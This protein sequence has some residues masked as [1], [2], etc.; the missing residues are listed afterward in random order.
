[1]LLFSFLFLGLFNES[2]ARGGDGSLI[3]NGGNTVMCRYEAGAEFQGFFTLDYL[4]DFRQSGPYSQTVPVASWEDSRARIAQGL[5]RLSPVLAKSF[6]EYAENILSDHV[7]LGR[8]WMPWDLTG[9]LIDDQEIT[10]RLPANCYLDPKTLDLRQTVVRRYGYDKVEYLY[11]QDILENLRLHNPLQFSFFMV[12]EWLWDFTQ[13]VRSLRR[14]NWILHSEEFATLKTSDWE[15][16]FERTQFFNRHLPV[17]HRSVAV[18]TQLWFQTGKA[19]DYITLEDISKIQTLD[20]SNLPA[21]YVFRSG[22][23]SGL[24]SL[25]TLDLSGS[26]G[27]IEQL[28]PFAFADLLNLQTIFAK[29]SGF[30]ELPE[31]LKEGPRAVQVR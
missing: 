29:G 17:C 15:I 11:Q 2:Q 27:I 23:F 1:M 14:L 13:D 26:P 6:Q 28:P 21:G 19:C 4:L 24:F 5:A 9:T 18:K 3:G 25:R 22:D 7:S 16:F 30:T 12:H 8:R 10:Q 31:H 20:L